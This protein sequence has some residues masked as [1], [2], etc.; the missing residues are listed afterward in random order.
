MRRWPIKLSFAFLPRPFRYSRAPGSVIEAQQF[1][2]CRTSD[3]LTA[4]YARTAESVTR[5]ARWLE[6]HGARYARFD[7]VYLG[8]DL[9][10]RQPICQAALDMGG[11]FLFVC[12]PVS[13]KAIEEFRA[14]IRLAARIDPDT[15]RQKMAPHRHQWLSGVPLRPG[16]T[17]SCRRRSAPFSH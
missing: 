5:Q 14:G 16:Q 6:A 7:A 10:S 3:F 13:H 2:L 17:P 15:D 11:H 1:S 12:K 4:S 8:D 9:F